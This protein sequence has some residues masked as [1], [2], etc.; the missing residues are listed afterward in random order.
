MSTA[1]IHKQQF[2]IRKFSYLLM[3]NIS[4]VSSGKSLEFTKTGK[5]EQNTKSWANSKPGKQFSKDVTSKSEKD[6]EYQA[7]GNNPDIFG[8][9]QKDSQMLSTIN[10][11][12]EEEDNK[13]EIEFLNNK[14]GKTKLTINQ[15][16]RIIKQFIQQKKIAYAIEVLEERMLKSDKVQPEN[17]IYNLLIGACGRFG[18]TKKAFKLYNDMKK[19]GLKV[20]PHTYTGLFNAC[21]NSPYPQ[22]GLSRAEHLREL[23]VEKGYSPNQT[24]YHAMIKAFGRCGD[25]ETAF[26]IVD[27][28]VDKKVLAS[29][30]TFNFLLQACITDRDAG[31]RH[32]LL[33]WRKM[34]EKGINPDRFTYNLMLRCSR[35][36]GMGD[37]TAATTVIQSVLESKPH[38][39]KKKLL[40]AGKLVTE[41]EGVTAIQNSN[42]MPDLLGP[43]PHLGS[44]VALNDV[45]LPEHRLMLMGGSS[46]FIRHM[47]LYNIKPDIKTFTQLL[48]QIPSTFA[49]E[50]VLLDDIYKLGLELDAEFCNMLIKKRCLRYDYNNA[51]E[52]LKIMSAANIQPDIVTFG[53]LAFTCQTLKEA[54]SLLSDIDNIGYRVNTEILGELLNNAC[55]QNDCDYIIGIMETVVK[56]NINPSSMF[57]ELLDS[58]YNRTSKQIS[59]KTNKINDIDFQRYCLYYKTWIKQVEPEIVPHPYHQFKKH[60]TAADEELLNRGKVKY[61]V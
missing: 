42:N 2:I 6:I 31:F 49:A 14:V 27:E 59:N 28:M 12:P 29:S 50:K 16:G 5:N 55:F 30:E 54:L 56:E 11:D 22:D 9:I 58:F 35:D 19:R 23:M 21:A 52:V 17:Y 61:S 40:P 7:Y 46:G 37:V 20:T 43:A 36:C 57:L 34:L 4:K 24:N 47:T 10:N 38:V 51:K 45:V 41:Q 25:L 13:E 8:T 26:S 48:D 32:A 60:A 39:T 18:Y 33:V 15:Y 44:I 53:V 1:V 3:R